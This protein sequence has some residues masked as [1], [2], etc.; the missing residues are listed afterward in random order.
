M[1]NIFILSILF[2][3][4]ASSVS[5]GYCPSGI[6]DLS[7]VQQICSTVCQGAGGWKGDYRVSKIGG[8]ISC[9]CNGDCPPSS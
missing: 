2:L 9:N 4:S 7:N 1:R 6:S 3:G 8:K 5:A